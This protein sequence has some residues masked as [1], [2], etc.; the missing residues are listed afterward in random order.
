[1]YTSMGVLSSVREI[2][3]FHPMQRLKAFST[4]GSQPFA[5]A[6]ARAS[7]RGRRGRHGMVLF[8]RAPVGK[9]AD[10][11]P[12]FRGQAGA[13][14]KGQ[15][16]VAGRPAVI[17]EDA[18]LPGELGEA[19]QNHQIPLRCLGQPLQQLRTAGGKEGYL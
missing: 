3:L 7:S 2:I 13:A 18:A 19:E 11:R 8:F 16:S 1:M 10:V 12:L 6:T 9:Q 5:T 15:R 14:Y 4:F 17:Q